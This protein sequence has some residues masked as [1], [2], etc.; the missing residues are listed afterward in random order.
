MEFSTKRY[1][2]LFLTICLGLFGVLIFFDGI[3]S[4]WTG[5]VFGSA[6]FVIG[7]F[8]FIAALRKNKELISILFFLCCGILLVVLIN[9]ILSALNIDGPCKIVVGGCRTREFWI[10]SAF[11]TVICLLILPLSWRTKGEYRD[12]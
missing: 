3:K 6:V 8:G 4:N 5:Y 1:L 11:L 12:Y 7:V 9:F 2:L 10:G